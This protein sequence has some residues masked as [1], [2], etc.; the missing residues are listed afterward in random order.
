MGEVAKL[1][2]GNEQLDLPVVVGTENERAVDISKLRAETG[3]ITLDEG[4][5]N[6]GSTTSAIT[7][8]DGEKGILR[9]RGYPI[10][11]IAE[12]CD[13]IETSYLL[14]YGEL[15]TAEQLAKFR[16]SLRRHTML[17]ED[18]RSFYNGFP[19]DAHP[20][21]ILS[22][23]VGALS[24]FYQD[25]L[26]PRDHAAARSFDPSA[27]R[28][29]ADDRGLCLQEIDRPAVHLSAERFVVLRELPA[30]DVRRAQRAVSRSTRI[31]SRRSTCC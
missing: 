8:L 17:H 11:V 14:I 22:S 25:S 15:P 12:R 20:M 3:Y 18:M 9:Y 4:Y 7:Y 1:K 29:A 27:D 19:R 13:F 5:V 21:A 23:V 31:S 10:E 26:N 2:I 24:T 6:T 28:Q 30:D 16:M